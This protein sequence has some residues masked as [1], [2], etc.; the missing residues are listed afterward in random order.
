MLCSTVLGKSAV[1]DVSF[2]QTPLTTPPAIPVPMLPVPDPTAAPTHEILFMMDMTPINYV[3]F[4]VWDAGLLD[5]IV[6]SDMIPS[7]F[8]QILNTS[9]FEDIAPG[10]FKKYP[11]L[12]MQLEVNVTEAPSFKIITTDTNQNHTALLLELPTDVIFQVLDPGKL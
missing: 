9:N 6:T 2:G 1:C 7:N 3:M 11:N 8:P 4:V 10:M 5:I 12:G